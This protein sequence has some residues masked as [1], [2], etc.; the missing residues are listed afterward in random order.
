M[1]ERFEDRPVPEDE[2]ALEALLRMRGEDDEMSK[3]FIVV[4]AQELFGC[5]F[6]L[7]QGIA[8]SVITR[9]SAE[10]KMGMIFSGAT[11]KLVYV[12]KRKLNLLYK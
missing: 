7:A 5:S 2:L 6:Q 11:D 12:W 3:E 1:P 4:T 8:N 10:G 9:C